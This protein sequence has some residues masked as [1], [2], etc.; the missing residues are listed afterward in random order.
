MYS[1][2]VL[3]VFKQCSQHH[4]YNWNFPF[5]GRKIDEE[6]SIICIEKFFE[7]KTYD[8]ELRLQMIKEIKI[9]TWSFHYNNK[10]DSHIRRLYYI[11]FAFFYIQNFWVLFLWILKVIKNYSNSLAS[12]WTSINLFSTSIKKKRHLRVKST[13]EKLEII[14]YV[15][16]KNR[17]YSHRFLKRV[18]SH[19]NLFHLDLALFWFGRLNFGLRSLSI[20]KNLSFCKLNY[21]CQ[22]NQNL[23]DKFFVHY[24]AIFAW[25][26][27]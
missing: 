6:Y 1:F 17:L 21:E 11:F 24:T 16:L 20:S 25:T 7:M 10:S 18:F 2:G 13:K 23:F 14:F 4:K 22:I 19:K 9:I 8:F 26:F 5:N 27:I 15:V 3:S 12:L